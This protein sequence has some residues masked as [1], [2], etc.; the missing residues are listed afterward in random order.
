MLP[1]D[2]LRL[3]AGL[4]FSTSQKDICLSF[5]AKKRALISKKVSIVRTKEILKSLSDIQAVFEY[6]YDIERDSWEGRAHGSISHRLFRVDGIDV[7]LRAGIRGSF[8]YSRHHQS[9]QPYV[10][11]SE[12]CW[13][14]ELDRVGR[15]KL[16]YL[17]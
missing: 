14:L 1:D 9:I 11:V 15:W 2:R 5:T 4:K 12:N 6:N 3:G 17:L 16:S 10:Q 7:C 8:S 13:S